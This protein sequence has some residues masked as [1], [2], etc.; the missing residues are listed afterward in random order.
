MENFAEIEARVIERFGGEQE[1]AARLTKPKSSRTIKKIP[2]ERWLSEASKAV[3]QAGFNWKVVDSKWPRIE[4][5]FHGFEL[6]FCRYLSDEALEEIL[7]Q[8]GMISHWKKTKSI[9]RNAD[10]F[11]QLSNVHGGLGNY[12]AGWNSAN[13]ADNLKSLQKGGDRL[14]GKTAQVFLRRMGVD[15]LV[16]S[17]D[18]VQGLI[19]AGV[20]QKKPSSKKD[21]AALQEAIE[22]WQGQ[23]GRSLNEISQILAFSVG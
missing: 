10:F 7:K 21:W 6:S 1:L 2:D 19:R 9:Q 16:F 14:G 15:T 18:M 13:Y 12:F 22:A 4:E 11:W 20:V 17:N 5:I 8:D 3:F 23:S